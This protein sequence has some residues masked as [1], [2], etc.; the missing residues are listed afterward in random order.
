MTHT[1]QLTKS[2]IAAHDAEDIRLATEHRLAN[3]NAQPDAEHRRRHVQV[4]DCLRGGQVSNFCSCAHCCLAVCSV[5]G[6]YEDALTTHCPGERVDFDTTQ[7]VYR[8][9]L[10]FTTY[11]G[12]HVSDQGMRERGPLFQRTEVPR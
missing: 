4:T 11:R 5:C 12:W 2:E 1:A 10:D 7:A 3:P 6:A 9:G 8:T